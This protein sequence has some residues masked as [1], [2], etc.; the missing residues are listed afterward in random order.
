MNEKPKSTKILAIIYG[1]AGYFILS[2]Y[3][4]WMVPTMCYAH[5]FTDEINQLSEFCAVEDLKS[6]LIGKISASDKLFA[7]LNQSDLF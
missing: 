7:F 4:D 1:S 5:L 2:F 3:S 6:I